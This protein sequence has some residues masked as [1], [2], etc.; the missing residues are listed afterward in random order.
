MVIDRYPALTNPWLMTERWSCASGAAARTV[1]S[2]IQ[3]QSDYFA[4]EAV[5][6]FR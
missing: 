3:H 2:Q 1:P 4:G 5:L 6:P